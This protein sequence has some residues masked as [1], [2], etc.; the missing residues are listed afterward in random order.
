MANMNLF[1]PCNNYNPTLKYD[2][3]YSSASSR[4]NP[5]SNSLLTQIFELARSSPA[6]DLSDSMKTVERKASLNLGACLIS[7][8]EVRLELRL[9]NYYIMK[10]VQRYSDRDVF[11][12]MESPCSSCF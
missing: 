10:I 1:H 6:I 2:S 3:I 5:L 9:K 8:D 12:E 11:L 7:S 4:F